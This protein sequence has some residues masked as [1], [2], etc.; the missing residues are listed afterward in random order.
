MERLGHTYESHARLCTPVYPIYPH[1][2]LCT[3]GVRLDH[4]Y[5]SQVLLCTLMYSCLPW[6]LLST[7]VYPSLACRESLG[8]ISDT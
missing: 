1:V 3:L 7:H 4:T 2:L 8:H 5:D 6:A